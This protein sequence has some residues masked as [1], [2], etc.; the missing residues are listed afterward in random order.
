MPAPPALLVGA[1]AAAGARPAR[2][3]VVRW[4]PAP[5]KPAS[6]G[7]NHDALAGQVRA[8]LAAIEALR[9]ANP[10]RLG[11]ARHAPNRWAANIGANTGKLFDPVYPFFEAGYAG[12][13]VEI[14]Q[15]MQ[16]A[17][18]ANLPWER[19][20]KSREAVTPSNIVG[21]LA[22]AGAPLSLDLFKID[23]DSH[24]VFVVRELLRNGT[25]R[26]KV[27]VM[28]INESVPPPL[29]FSVNFARA[30]GWSGHDAFM[31][32]SVSMVDH[33]LTPLGYVLVDV[34][35]NNVVLVAE[36]YAEAFPRHSPADLWRV[37]YWERA[38][39]AQ[40][41]PWNEAPD[42]LAYTAEPDPFEALRI[43]SDAM[44]ASD[45]Y[46]LSRSTFALYVHPDYVDT[47]AHSLKTTHCADC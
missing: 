27:I 14:A 10:Q 41:F 25:F 42:R 4:L 19:V 40:A 12:L 3:A 18:H 39:R 31:G 26:P 13:A 45:T 43:L 1:A 24:D 30:F 37:G 33:Q 47:R 28:E 35:W 17:L 29:C 21:L 2:A 34:E 44:L 16:A 8:T 6:Q 7:G 15:S 32:C 36:E 20:K 46:K 23:I 22:G 9:A 11:E 38:G 5:P